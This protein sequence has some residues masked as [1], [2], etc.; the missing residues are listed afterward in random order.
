MLGFELVFFYFLQIYNLLYNRAISK[1]VKEL[2]G[3]S[4]FETF[5]RLFW[6]CLLS[7]GLRREFN[8]SEDRRSS[9]LYNYAVGVLP[10]LTL[11]H[12]GRENL[13]A[14]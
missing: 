1:Y 12:L 10:S 8:M 6:V 11:G 13:N 14:S 9:T 7:N 5:P 4:F 3:S 2:I